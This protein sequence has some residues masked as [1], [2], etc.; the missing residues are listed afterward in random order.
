M[1]C[2][3]IVSY[4]IQKSSIFS[5]VASSM[6]NTAPW[7]VTAITSRS[8]LSWRICI[9]YHICVKYISEFLYCPTLVSKMFRVIR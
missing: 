8:R 3:R 9:L 4:R 1:L 6:S 2:V 7:R 5:R